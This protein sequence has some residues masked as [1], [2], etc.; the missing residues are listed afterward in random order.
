MGRLRARW[1]Y[2]RLVNVRAGAGRARARLVAA[3]ARGDQNAVDAL[4]NLWYAWEDDALL[5]ELVRWGRP[6]S[7]A[8]LLNFSMVVL[9]DERADRDYLLWLAQRFDHPVYDFARRYVAEAGDQT[10]VDDFCRMVSDADAE[11][12]RLARFC[13][14]TGLAPA[15]PVDRAG[16]LLLTG[17]RERYAAEDP[18]G[19]L[20]AA[21]Y[22]SGSHPLSTRIQDRLLAAPDLSALRLLADSEGGHLTM[23][24]EVRHMVDGLLRLGRGSESLALLLKGRIEDLLRALPRFPAG[25]EPDDPA[26]RALFTR[27]R[28]AAAGGAVPSAEVLAYE[29]EWPSDAPPGW[30]TLVDRPMSLLGREQLELARAELARGDLPAP[31]RRLLAPLEACLTRRL[32]QRTDRGQPA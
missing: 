6:S 13:A 27:L 17:Q 11:E 18:D 28:E 5:A 23:D 12:P 3:G 26:D 2:W 4:W 31:V 8:A 21:F 25:W 30:L 20:L 7:D 10:L 15:D 22:P 29:A 32:D 16:F 14:A 24:D 9:R 19:R 1:L